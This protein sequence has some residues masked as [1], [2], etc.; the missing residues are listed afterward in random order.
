[1][2]EAQQCHFL[3]G[4]GQRGVADSWMANQ[5]FW[6]TLALVAVADWRHRSGW[7]NLREPIGQLYRQH[8]KTNAS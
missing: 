4:Y 7:P 1:M 8:L 3:R 6:T 2:T 5:S